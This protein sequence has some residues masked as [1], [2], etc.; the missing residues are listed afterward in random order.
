MT[1]SFIELLRKQTRV[2]QLP[3]LGPRDSLKAVSYT[4][5]T[6][7]RASVCRER[8]DILTAGPDLASAD[9]SRRRI[10]ESGGWKV[11][12]QRIEVWCAT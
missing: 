9:P 1:L 5:L 6:I 8:P 3:S 2:V 12:Y 11:H 4:R 7:G 10:S